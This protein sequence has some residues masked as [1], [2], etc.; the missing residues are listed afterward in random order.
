MG[1]EAGDYIKVVFKDESQPIGEWMWVRGES[2]DEKNRLVFGILVASGL[3]DI[4][5]VLSGVILL[6]AL[7]F[8][9]YFL[10]GEF[11][12]RLKRFVVRYL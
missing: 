7:A 9:L 3:F 1:Y 4:S 11:E 6:S 12:P 10:V 5:L 2:C 8:L